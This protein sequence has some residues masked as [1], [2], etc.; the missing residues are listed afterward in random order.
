MKKKIGI[1]LILLS[2]VF[3]LPGAFAADGQISVFSVEATAGAGHD[4]YLVMVRPDVT[5]RLSPLSAGLEQ[6][7][8]NLY[9]ADSIQDAAG[10]W[11]EDQVLH[12]EPNYRIDPL[13]TPNDPKFYRQWDMKMINAPLLWQTDIS[14]EGVRVAILDT[15]IVW[16]HEDLNYANVLEG[17]NYITNTTAVRDNKGH[18]TAVAGII[19]ATRNNGLGMAGLVCEVTIIPLQVMDVDAGTLSMA[20][21]AIND[22]VDIHDADVI[23]MSFSVRGAQRSLALENAVDFA[24]AQGV[25]LVAAVGNDGNEVVHYPA[26]YDNVIGVGAV[27][28]TGTKADFSQRNESVFVTAPGC[29]VLSLGYAGPESYRYW[30]GTS[31]A[32][33]FVTAMA[34]AAKGVR[35]DMTQGEFAEILAGSA[36]DAGVSGYDIK[37]GHGIIDLARFVAAFPE[38]KQPHGFLDIDGHWAEAGILRA[39]D[40][41]LVTGM[42][43]TTFEPDLEMSR[44]M[45]VTILGRLYR[46]T[47]GNIPARNDTFVDTQRDSW[48]SPYV[49]WAA[50]NGIVMGVGGN[51]FAPEVPVTRQEA[52]VIL[53]RFAEYI[54]R[55]VSTGGANLQGFIDAHRVADWARPGMLWGVDKGLITGISS[56]GGMMLNP[57]GIFTRAEAAV[58]LGRFIDLAGVVLLAA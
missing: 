21:R 12:I 52:A 8:D 11:R 9:R 43:A 27:D 40:L 3:L 19:A 14:A 58:L 32:A 34:A 49:A 20:I 56:G 13:G 5:P 42:T 16:N 10:V 6:I 55:D 53:Y 47:G 41:G 23:N 54:G 46:E 50:E 33:P 22:A 18:G 7:A 48:Y 15:G 29:A 30:D 39:V 28:R 24:A 45:I 36:R 31:F 4:G 26:G 38:V 35:P 57:E 2:I 37:Y 51:R 44:A 1:F 17:F 25:I